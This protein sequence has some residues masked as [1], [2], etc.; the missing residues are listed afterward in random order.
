MPGVRLSGHLGIA[1]AY[2]RRQAQP[3]VTLQLCLSIWG[4]SSPGLKEFDSIIYLG[5][6]KSIQNQILLF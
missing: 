2:L 4:C 6:I 1:G 5:R 3:L